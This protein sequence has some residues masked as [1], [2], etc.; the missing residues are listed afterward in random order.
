MA[1]INIKDISIKSKPISETDNVR[2]ILC[3]F[4]YGDV[5]FQKITTELEKKATVF[6]YTFQDTQR[7]LVNIV[8]NFESVLD[9]HIFIKSQSS[10][11]NVYNYVDTC[12]INN[13]NS[14]KN[15][16]K[17]SKRERFTI[18]YDIE[19]SDD[20]ILYLKGYKF[21]IHSILCF[22]GL[23]I[24]QFS[25][26]FT[27]D[28]DIN[29]TK[30]L[31]IKYS[32]FNFSKK[33]VLKFTGNNKVLM[34]FEKEIKV[35]VEVSSFTRRQSFVRTF[36]PLV[37][38]S[39]SY[40]LH[41]K[42]SDY[43][44]E[45]EISE[46]FNE[47]KV[48]R[49]EFSWE[50]SNHEKLN[51]KPF[52]KKINKAKDKLT[53]I[54]KGIK[55]QETAQPRPDSKI[56]SQLNT[57]I[58]PLN[59]EENNRIN[60]FITEYYQEFLSN[61]DYQDKYIKELTHSQYP[62]MAYPVYPEPAYYYLKQISERF[63]LPASGS[64]PDN[65][66][67]LFV[68]NPAFVEAFLCGMNTEMGRELLWREYPTDSR[69]SYFRKFWDTEI[70]KDIKEELRSDTFFDILPIHKWDYQEGDAGYM[71]L[72]THKLGQNHTAGKDNLLIFAIKGELLKKYPETIIY[73]SKASLNGNIILINPDAVKILPDLSA[74]LS[75]DTY[76]VGFPAKLHELTGNPATRDP[77]YFL[78][79]MN[80][81]GETRF[82]SRK[83]NPAKTMNNAAETAANL[84][85]QPSMFG[86]HIS[87]FLSGWQNAP[88]K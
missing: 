13:K 9:M 41:G 56:S 23:I 75:E 18:K 37:P 77:G 26:S 20:E 85:V 11:D 46:I 2:I 27:P 47:E 81:P 17:E 50:L 4:N 1:R 72:K 60:Q 49:K 82:A 28:K 65:S 76:I 83:D 64:M 43:D 54:Y 87:Q 84:L 48:Q 31:S 86:K 21:Q 59:S 32:G 29:K 15:E 40:K 12:T 73:L 35:T 69:G 66:I 62:V 6:N 44:I 16:Y 63:I 58:N 51:L 34:E 33:H 61:P 88:Q 19:N 79:F 36:I 45:Y 78:T 67:A 52:S 10:N 3:P 24:D 8:V 80:R 30:T 42:D 22:K 39:G 57:D 7:N 5:D 14:I 53:E 68:N 38:T 74:W 71:P 55:P 70:K 25:F